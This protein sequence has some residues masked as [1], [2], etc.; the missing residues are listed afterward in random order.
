MKKKQIANCITSLRLIGTL[1]LLFTKPFSKVFYVIYTLCGVTDVLD[2]LVARLTK[3]TSEF[4]AKLDSIADLLFYAVMIIQAFPVLWDILPVWVWFIA[5]SVAAVRVVSYLTAAIKY[6]KFAAMHTYL[7][8]LT[9]I[10]VFVVPYFVIWGGLTPV[11]VA[12]CVV[13][14][15]A[16][17][18]ELIIHLRQKS[19]KSVKSIVKII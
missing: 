1:C 5:L 12:V 2:G 7:N 4:G 10:L 13:A 9:G 14:L 19:Y 11:S 16:A 17:V 15:L 6:K 8:K 18:E 3:S